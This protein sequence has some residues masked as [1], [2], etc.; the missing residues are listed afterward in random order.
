MKTKNNKNIFSLVVPNEV[1]LTLTNTGLALEGAV[2][3]LSVDL[4][5][6]DPLGLCA[7]A[8][9]QNV[10]SITPLYKST[11]AITSAKTM[12]SLLKLKIE[13]VRV[14]YMCKMAVKGVG[15]RVNLETSKNVQ[16]LN[17]KL[18]YSHDVLYELPEDVKA[19]CL[20]PNTFCLYGLDT[21]KVHNVAAKLIQLRKPDSYKGKGIYLVANPPQVKEVSKR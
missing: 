3:S 15:F 14:G 21:A 13:G 19:F 4:K 2:G 5:A 7:Y 17:F 1:Q 10:F 6:L 20:D 9:K 8:Y 11:R 18:G 16:T 12:A